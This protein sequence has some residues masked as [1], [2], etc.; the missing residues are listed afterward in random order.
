MLAV[1]TAS[2]VGYG[3]L[4]PTTA[5]GRIIAIFVMAI[6]VAFVSLLT[7]AIAARF[8]R[9]E[10]DGT[11]ELHKALARIEADVAEIKARLG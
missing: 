10:E 7:A 1:V 8:V 2:T 9:T 11:A 3:D 6:G 5:A 4:V